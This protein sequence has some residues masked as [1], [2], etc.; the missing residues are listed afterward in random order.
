MRFWIVVALSKTSS[1]PIFSELAP[2]SLAAIFRLSGLP[3]NE[4]MHRSRN[5]VEAY[6]TSV[7]TRDGAEIFEL[8][9]LCLREKGD[10]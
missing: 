1:W 6:S 10:Q 9:G 4:K 8:M 3:R 5:R 2:S 7:E